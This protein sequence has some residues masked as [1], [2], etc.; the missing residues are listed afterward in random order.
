MENHFAMRVVPRL[1]SREYERLQIAT[2]EGAVAAIEGARVAVVVLGAWT[3]DFAAVAS[4][5]QKERLRRAL[6]DCYA[7]RLRLDTSDVYER[8]RCAYDG[9]EPATRTGA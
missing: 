3:K 6:T 1:I 5:A 4:E 9:Q 2:P 8:T 7:L